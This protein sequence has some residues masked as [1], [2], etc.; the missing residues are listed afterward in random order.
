MNRLYPDL[1]I[2]FLCADYTSTDLDIIEPRLYDLLSPKSSHMDFN[3]ACALHY[4]SKGEG[5][6]FN[7]AYF[8]DPAFKA[9]YSKISEAFQVKATVDRA[10][11]MK[12]GNSKA[13]SFDYGMISEAV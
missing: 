4:A 1:T 8:E 13:K 11:E 2:R 12:K 3:I 6:L 7:D 9:D 5:F 10:E